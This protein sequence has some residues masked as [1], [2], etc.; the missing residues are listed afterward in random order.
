MPVLVNSFIF[1]SALGGAYH[2]S[3]SFGSLS[4][5]SHKKLASLS[6]CSFGTAF[7]ITTYPF[8]SQN[9]QSSSL[10]I[11]SGFPLLR[12]FS[13]TLLLLAVEGLPGMSLCALL[14]I[15]G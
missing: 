12:S 5:N 13:F 1:I 6:A 11:F 8:V 14:T 3:G 4:S 2:V 9:C 15:V 10:S 7:F